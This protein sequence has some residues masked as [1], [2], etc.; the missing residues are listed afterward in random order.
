MLSEIPVLLCAL[1]VVVVSVSAHGYVQQLLISGVYYTGYLPFHDP[2]IRPVPSRIVRQIPDNGP[3]INITSPDLACNRGGENG[4]DVNAGSEITFLWTP[5]G[6]HHK[7]PVGTYMASCNGPCSSFSTSN[8]K[9]FKI[10]AS[11]Y[12]N[13]EWDSSK[14]IAANNTWTTIIP[15][16]L[17]SGQYLIRNEIV[18]LHF[19]GAPGGL[20]QFYP[21]CTLGPKCPTFLRN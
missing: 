18:A 21:S 16:G 2:T 14:L 6:I 12:E 13:N 3:V 11:G 19:V 7:G 1:S 5:W 10:N 15:A 8:A 17:A 20:L 4:T 9:W